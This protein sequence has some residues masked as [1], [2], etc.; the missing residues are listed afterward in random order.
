MN[1]FVGNLSFDAT[2]ADLRKLFEGF[3]A[4][5]SALIVMERKEAKSRG[6]GFVDMPDD[7]QAQA[8]IDAC[9]GREFMGR[10]LNVSQAR[11]KQEA[12]EKQKNTLEQRTIAGRQFLREKQ[13]RKDSWFTPVFNKPGVHRGRRTRSFVSKRTAEGVEEKDIFKPPK[14]DNPMRWRKNTPQ[15]KPWNKTHSE[16]KPW[17]KYART[18]SPLTKHEERPEA[19][20]KPE[21][22]ARPWRKAEE[23]GRPWRKPVGSPRGEDRPRTWGDSRLGARQRPWQS[24]GERTK[25]WRRSEEGGSPWKK[26]EAG[27][28]RAGSDNFKPASTPWRKPGS[29]FGER[30]NS[31]SRAKPERSAPRGASKPGFPP[32]RNSASRPK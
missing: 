12:Q 19:W 15:S 24:S 1:I 22:G 9:N 10:E 18:V 8:A 32:R 20:R 17:R 13:E 27:R 28:S 14:R 23:G 4:V 25:P 11:A 2:E 16:A 7:R 31:Y 6:F 3:G 30:P 26:P 21:A 29:G 5:A